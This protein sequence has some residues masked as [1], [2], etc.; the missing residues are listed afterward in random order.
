[1]GMRSKICP[2]CRSMMW[3][4]GPEDQCPVCLLTLGVNDE[5]ESGED[6]STEGTEGTV[7][8]FGIA[9]WEKPGDSID[10][11]K[12]VK[13]IGEGGFGTVWMAEQQEPIRRE[14]ALKI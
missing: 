11:Y 3:T 4:S 14:V 7:S 2:A 10:G 5:Q 1:M 9:E 13:P 6:H 8:N 12:L